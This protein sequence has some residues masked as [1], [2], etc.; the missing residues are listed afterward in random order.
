MGA[1]YKLIIPNGYTTTEWIASE[2]GKGLGILFQVVFA[3][4]A[5]GLLSMTFTA[6]YKYI[7]FINVGNSA[8]ITGLIVLGTAIYSLRGGMKVSLLTGTIQTLMNFVLICALLYLGISY[9][10]DVDL[11]N[12]ITGKKNVT[13][14]FEPKLFISFAVSATL[15]FITAPMMSAAHHQKSFSQQNKT[16]WKTWAWGGP[17]YFVMQTMI[18]TF[19]LLA[20][21][22]G[23]QIADP[24]I[25]QLVFFNA[26]GVTALALFGVILLNAGCMI[27]DAHGNAFASIIAHD[28]VKDET[29]SVSVARIAI[30]GIATVAWLISL[31]NIDLTYIFFTYGTLRVNLFIILVLILTTSVLTKRGIFWTAVVMCPATTALGLYGMINKDPTYNAAATVIGFFLT[32]TIAY[33]ASKIETAYIENK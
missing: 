21:A 11:A 27:I 18:A 16:P 5:L 19:G 9:L 26:I 10:P 2:Y 24:S 1:R 32:P 22:W 14:L 15:T 33:I 6:I 23:G 3:F 4:S 13:D 17:A 28:F 25:G 12:F 7:N 30:L 8:L 31:A 29:K 20:C